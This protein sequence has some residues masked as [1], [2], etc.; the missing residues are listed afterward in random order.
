MAV[1]EK[2]LKTYTWSAKNK[3]GKTIKGEH[4]M[5][6]E[7]VLKAFLSR[8]G[9][10]NIQ[11]R[12]KAKPVFESK[13]RIKSSNI[14]FFTRQMA[15]M[16]RAGMPVMRSLEL[17][18][19]SI[20]RPKAMQE[21][22]IDV[23][24]RIQNGASFAEALAAHPVYFNNLYTSLVAAGEEA[25]M[26]EKTMDNLG[27]NLEKNEAVK[28]KIKKALRYPIIVLCFAAIVTAILMI[29]VIP[30]FAEFFESNGGQL[31]WIT[32]FVMSISDFLID[33]GAYL[34]I[35]TIAAIYGFIWLKKRNRNFEKRVNRLAF[36]A[37][38]IGGIIRCGAVARFAGTMS[39]LF[40]AGVPM[41]K[42]LTAVAPA[43]GSV[44]FEEAIYVIRD[45][46]QNGQQ[47]S[48]AMKNSE[49]FPIV[50]VQMTAIGEESG[51]LGEMLGRV[52]LFYEEELDWRI[53]N[54]TSMIEPLIMAF[55]GLV[56]GG[57]LMAMYL[58]MFQIG[59]LF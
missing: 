37:P 6:S 46:V 3:Q 32:Q 10:T 39:I 27:T 50:A 54:L 40:N 53:D 49:L 8:Q 1:E 35:I 29:K 16:L 57:L 58:P 41:I 13:G 30:V 55:L 17:V 38:L 52:G 21:I 26:L 23:F 33:K 22:V 12:E 28:K 47:L 36:K 45:N 51:N 44:V 56:V 43:V 5:A 24:N 34:L 42:G 15:T 14:V 9:L 31:P 7:A 25:G 2:K 18:G 59:D 4:D 48:F 11:V 20:E 19:Q